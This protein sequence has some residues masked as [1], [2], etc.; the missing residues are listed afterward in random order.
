M[1]PSNNLAPAELQAHFLNFDVGA[2][3][4][5]RFRLQFSFRRFSRKHAELCSSKW[6]VRRQMTPC[7]FLQSSECSEI[8]QS[9]AALKT[10]VLAVQTYSFSANFTGGS[11]G[12][13]RAGKPRQLPA[14][15]GEQVDS[16][17]RCW[18]V[19]KLCGSRTAVWYWYL[20]QFY[21]EL[22]FCKAFSLGFCLFCKLKVTI[23]IVNS[24]GECSCFV[25]RSH[26]RYVALWVAFSLR[27]G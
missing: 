3:A 25:I 23:Q 8:E 20:E 17:R 24:C 18:L 26:L 22:I 19:T 15:N 12:Q 5:I 27:L 16:R 10:A 21:A 11:R 6:G 1:T 2:F 4:I 7:F 14:T 9:L 13:P